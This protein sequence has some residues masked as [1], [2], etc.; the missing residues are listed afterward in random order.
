M[1]IVINCSCL[2][3]VFSKSLVDAFLTTSPRFSDG[4]F[5]TYSSQISLIKV[6]MRLVFD[7]HIVH[8]YRSVHYLCKL[9]RISP[10]ES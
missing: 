6:S 5:Q 10:N 4:C 9:N 1:V 3:M 2:F 7:C 8:C